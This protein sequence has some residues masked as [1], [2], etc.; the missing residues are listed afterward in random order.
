[1]V[2][3]LPT[4]QFI[5]FHNLDPKTT[6]G[7]L[8]D[9]IRNRTGIEIPL[10]RI[11]VATYEFSSRAFVSLDRSH[12]VAIMAWALSEDVCHG[13]AFQVVEPKAR[14]AA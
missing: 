6:E 3:Q 1:M 7:D 8:Q 9:L 13:R 5:V 11:N 12:V 2:K 14:R 10:E 4:G